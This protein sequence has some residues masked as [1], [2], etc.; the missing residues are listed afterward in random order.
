VAEGVFEPDGVVDAV[1]LEDEV[2]D[3][4]ADALVDGEA[5]GT[6]AALSEGRRVL[7]ITIAAITAMAT[8]P[9]SAAG[10]SRLLRRTLTLT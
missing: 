5:L 10:Q 4:L 3:A 6:A 9:R 7:M 1:A 8:A 2:A